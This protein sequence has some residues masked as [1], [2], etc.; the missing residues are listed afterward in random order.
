[1][2]LIITPRICGL[3]LPH[4]SEFTPVDV[5]WSSMRFVHGR[6]LLFLGVLCESSMCFTLGWL[7]LFRRLP[8]TFGSR[9][10]D[11]P[12]G[13][14]RDTN[15][16]YPIKNN[17]IFAWKILLHKQEEWKTTSEAKNPLPLSTSITDIGKGWTMN[18]SHS[19]EMCSLWRSIRLPFISQGKRW[20]PYKC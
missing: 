5:I 17:T 13:R 19:D 6:L 11:E 15:F 10:M 14:A 8:W 2:G 9:L 12:C 7:L 20:T 16:Y 3:N 4:M 1:M 18:Y